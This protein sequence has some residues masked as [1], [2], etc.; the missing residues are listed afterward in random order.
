MAK[1]GKTSKTTQNDHK[2]KL[3][4][5]QRIQRE[6]KISETHDFFTLFVHSRLAYPRGSKPLTVSILYIMISGREKIIET[7]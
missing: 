5:A 1:K 3:F 7:G 2:E 6:K 4:E